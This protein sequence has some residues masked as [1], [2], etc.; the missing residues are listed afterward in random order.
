MSGIEVDPETS[1]FDISAVQDS[2][3][4]EPK[5]PHQ[6]LKHKSVD[7]HPLAVSVDI[8]SRLTK[9][10]HDFLEA[11]YRSDPKPNT[12]TKKGYAESMNVSFDKIDVISRCC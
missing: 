2:G 8:Q 3:F 11:Q 9:Q 6:G 7:H 10:Q 4:P 1:Y 5:Y 12:N